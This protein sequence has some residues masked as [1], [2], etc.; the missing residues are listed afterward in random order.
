MRKTS[1]NLNA[2]QWAVVAAAAAMVALAAFWAQANKAPIRATAAPAAVPAA[3]PAEPAPWLRAYSD[4]PVN[5]WEQAPASSGGAAASGGA[6]VID[7]GIGLD[8]FV[9]TTVVLGLLYVTLRALKLWTQR[10][11]LGAATSN[12]IAVMETTYLAP[13]RALHVVRVGSRLL[14]LGATASSIALITEIAAEPE[15]VPPEMEAADLAAV[16]GANRQQNAGS[17]LN[18]LRG[19][20]ISPRQPGEVS[21]SLAPVDQLRQRMGQLRARYASNARI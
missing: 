3:A 8:L 7:A 6:D 1:I 14:L 4:L 17:F 20:A 10:Q 5:S 15:V 21:S 11:K 18:A 2:K 13:N 16:L 9:K 12:S 19:A